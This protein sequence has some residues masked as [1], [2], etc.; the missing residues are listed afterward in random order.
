MFLITNVYDVQ[1][2]SYH[3]LL[4]V[5]YKFKGIFNHKVKYF[6][7]FL[8]IDFYNMVYLQEHPNR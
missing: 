2:V 5:L 8:L 4:Q 3:C 7:D 1:L 6:W